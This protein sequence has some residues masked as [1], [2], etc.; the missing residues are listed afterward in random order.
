MKN[1]TNSYPKRN[2]INY[3]WTF[4]NKEADMRTHRSLSPPKTPGEGIMCISNHCLNLK[5]L[6]RPYHLGKFREPLDNREIK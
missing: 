1:K 2:K 3:C 5:P 4:T 6:E